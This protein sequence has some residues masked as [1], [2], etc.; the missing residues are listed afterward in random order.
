MTADTAMEIVKRVAPKLPFGQQ[1]DIAVE[2][3]RA[4]HAGVNEEMAFTRK[5]MGIEKS[6]DL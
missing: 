1:C 3:I 6:D 5:L 4:F 2:L